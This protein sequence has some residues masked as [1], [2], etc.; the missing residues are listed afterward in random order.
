GGNVVLPQHG[1]DGWVM[2]G[3]IVSPAVNSRGEIADQG[4]EATGAVP[5]FDS[6]HSHGA[7]SFIANE[8]NLTLTS[9]LGE[10]AVASASV[11]FVPRS[12]SDFQL[13]DFLDVD[14]A[15][16]EWMPT[17]AQRTSI[18]VGKFDSVIGIEYRER[19]AVQR[20]GITPS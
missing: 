11:N 1:N 9:G 3:D 13:G 6:V 19:K 16:L 14:I 8:V 15:Q 4:T 17:K 12:G 10:S 2:M 5:R 18:F 20:F 7:P